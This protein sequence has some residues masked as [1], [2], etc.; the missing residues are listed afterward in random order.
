MA[1]LIFQIIAITSFMF[2]LLIL[3]FILKAGGHNVRQYLKS[4][5]PG[6]KF[7]GAWFIQIINNKVRFNFQPI[8]QDMRIKIK[9]GKTPDEDEYASITEIQHQIDGEGVPVLFTIEDLPFT[10]FLKKHH[11]D[12][13]YPELNQLIKFSEAC[14]LKKDIE[15]GNLLKSSIK[16]FLSKIKEPM[17]YIP[18]AKE[19]IMKI[20]ALYQKNSSNQESSLLFLIDTTKHLNVIKD[21]ISSNNHQLVNAN[22]LFKT[23][24]YLK[25]LVKIMFMEFQNGVL[26]SS[27]TKVDKRV[28]TVLIALSIITGILVIFSL[29]FSFQVNKQMTELTAQVNTISVNVDNLYSEIGISAD[30]QI[31]ANSIPIIP[32]PDNPLQ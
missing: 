14:I 2:M 29:F 13:L 4:K 21:L 24:G 28:N 26:A 32:V 7:K 25:N 5:L 20:E 11:L 3:V 9:S 30:N 8:P 22:S 12:A 17:K 18:N 19:E 10:F 31:D 15:T 16:R 6:K 27:Q 23:T 1:S